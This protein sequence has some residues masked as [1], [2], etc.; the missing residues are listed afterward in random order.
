MKIRTRIALALAGV[1]V[2]CSGVAGEN[3]S[4]DD[5]RGPW[6][7][8]GFQPTGTGGGST[9]TG[10]SGG[11]GGSDN[12][13]GTGAGGSTTGTGGSTTGTGGST[14]T[15]G[16]GGTTGGAGGASGSGGSGATGGGG[17][18]GGLPPG[19]GGSTGG[20]GGSGGSSGTGGTGTGGTGGTG[21]GGSGGTG[22]GGTGGAGTGGT[23]GAG[24]TGTGGTGGTGTGGTGGAAGTG[25]AGGSGGTSTTCSV[26]VSVTTTSAGGRFAPKNIGAIWIATSSGGFVKSL[27]VWAQQRIQYLTSWQSATSAAGSKANVID[28]VTG[29]TILTHQTHTASWNCTDFKKA[30][31]ADGAY[32]VYFEMT[33]KDGAGPN[34]FVDFTKGSTAVTVTPPDATNFKSM[35]VVFT[36]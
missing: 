25:G 4:L 32:R 24:G 28:A 6:D 12:G 9:G 31:A 20:A 10:G 21:T 18:S 14:T 11:S 1:L 29:A 15:G 7:A 19:D 33:D 5:Y 2:G 8:G 13:T 22:T 17:G 3:L 16:S 30:A 36:P 23:G 34:T 35:K 27:K 26:S